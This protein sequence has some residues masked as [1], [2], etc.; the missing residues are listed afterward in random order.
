MDETTEM[1]RRTEP[2]AARKR[3]RQFVVLGSDLLIWPIALSLAY[4][5]YGQ[6]PST[7]RR[8]S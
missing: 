3:L 6:G 2:T 5:F 4:T 7:R 8:S 1:Q